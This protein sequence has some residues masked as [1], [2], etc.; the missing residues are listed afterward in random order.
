MNCVVNFANERGNYIKGQQRLVKSLMDTKWQGSILCFQSEE[1][2]ENCPNHLDNPYAF[3]IY[4]IYEAVMRGFN[5]I[6][7]IDASVWAIKPIDEIFEVI[8]SEGYIMQEAGHMVGNWCNESTLNYFNLTREE[9]LKMPMYG[10][11]GFLG[12]NF[13]FQIAREF[14]SQWTESM[15]AGCFKGLWSDHRHDMT[16][17][18]IIANRLGMKYKSG[19][20]YLQYAAPED[21]PLNETIILKAQGL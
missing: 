11:A 3:K 14:F 20:S 17:G 13:D 12:L 16:C 1:Q 8:D 4:A 15:Q 9:A 6:L 2:L 21:R 7:F 18:S 10:N 19:H 5:K